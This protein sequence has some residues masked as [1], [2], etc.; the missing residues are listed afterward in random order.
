[1]KLDNLQEIFNQKIFRIPDYQRGYSWEERQCRDL[2]QDIDILPDC[3]DHYTGVLTVV[4]K[5][6]EILIVDGQQRLATLI[7]LIQVIYEKLVDDGT[8]WVNEREIAD[9]EKQYLHFKRGKQGEISDVVFGYQKDNPSHIYFKK[10]ILGASDTTSNVPDHTLYTRNLIDAKNFFES[11]IKNLSFE[12]LECLLKKVTTQLRFNYY[13]LD[14]ELNQFVAFET[15]NNRGKPLSTLELL[16]NRLIYLSTL[17]PE[18]DEAEKED[19]RKDINNAWQTVYEFLGKNPKDK[20]VDDDFLRDHWIMNFQYSR[21]ESKVYRDFLLSKHFTAERTLKRKLM[22]ADI[23][24]YVTDIQKA[25]KAYYYLHNPADSSCPYSEDIKKWLRKLNRLGFGAFTP[26]LTSIL[27]KEW[28]NSKIFSV[29]E[30]AERFVFVAFDVHFHRSSKMNS[31][32]YSYANQIHKSASQWSDSEIQEKLALSKLEIKDQL[33]TGSF[34]GGVEHNFYEW[35][36][37]KYFLYEYELH[38]KELTSGD[39]KVLWD[40]VNSE[41]IEHIYPQSPGERWE[42]FQSKDKELLHDLG[43][44]L[45]LSRKKN[46]ALQNA[47]FSEKCNHVNYGYKKGSYSAIEVADESDWTPDSIIERRNKLIDFLCERWGLKKLI[48]REALNNRIFS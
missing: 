15:M 9:Y 41:T 4:S 36:G 27:S 18:N 22:L 20:L 10:E 39:D 35:K 11:K 29:L 45:L 13:E 32:I 34:S 37:L 46:G 5:D 30:Y 8:E 48:V 38:L 2:W 1:M 28:R 25:A 31:R 6:S 3:R 7:I 16:K 42:K 17:L 43:N 24:E 40:S 19:L 33:D 14:D 23:R 47:S 44:L 12:D 26:L 21:E